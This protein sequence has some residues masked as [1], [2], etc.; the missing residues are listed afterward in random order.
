LLDGQGILIPF[1]LHLTGGNLAEAVE[2]GWSESRTQGVQISYEQLLTGS[3][4]VAK[5]FA[6][7]VSVLLYLCSE[8]PDHSDQRE[9]RERPHPLFTI[10]ERFH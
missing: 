7:N 9:I 1:P 5:T 8:E 3:V 4:R 10:L 2:A 6:P